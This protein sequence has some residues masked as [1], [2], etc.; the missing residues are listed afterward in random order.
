MKWTEMD[1]LRPI[2]VGRHE[3]GISTGRVCKEPMK[4]GLI[5]VPV[6]RQRLFD[7]ASSHQEET[8]RVA[9]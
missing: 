7:R 5:K 6:G 3:W 8:D 2:D 1:C 9:E 4:T